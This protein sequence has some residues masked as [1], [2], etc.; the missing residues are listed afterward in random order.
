MTPLREHQ[1]LSRILA[2]ST[3]HLCINSL[4]SSLDEIAAKVTIE[5]GEE[6]ESVSSELAMAVASVKQYCESVKLLRKI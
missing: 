6:Y 5:D 1:Q 4:L 3:V 2:L